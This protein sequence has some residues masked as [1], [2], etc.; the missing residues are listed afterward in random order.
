MPGESGPPA[1][2]G[3]QCPCPWGAVGVGAAL[4]WVLSGSVSSPPASCFPRAV[5]A[6]SVCRLGYVP[7]VR[8]LR[9]ARGSEGGC[10]GHAVVLAASRSPWAASAAG[11]AVPGNFGGRHGSTFSLRGR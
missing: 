4:R 7:D 11:A 9:N 5:G 3:A 10:R 2:L 8:F 6:S 1:C